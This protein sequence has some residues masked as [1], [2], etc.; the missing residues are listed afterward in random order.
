[1]SLSAIWGEKSEVSF[2]RSSH[3][4]PWKYSRIF[5]RRKSQK[6]SQNL[7]PTFSP[8]IAD[9][10]IGNLVFG[11]DGWIHLEL[12]AGN[13]GEFGGHSRKK[14]R[15][16]PEVQYAVLFWTLDELVNRFGEVGV[17]LINDRKAADIEYA[18]EKLR[19]YALQKGYSHISV[20]T[21]PGDYTSTNFSSQLAQ[22]ERE[23]Y[24]SIHL[25]N[26]EGHLY[27]S[28]RQKE[29]FEKHRQS[30][31][32]MLQ[33]LAD[34][35]YEG[36]YLFIL[37]IPEFLPEEEKMEFMDQGIFY[38]TTQEWAAVDYYFP[39]GNVIEGGRVFFILRSD[40]YQQGTCLSLPLPFEPLHQE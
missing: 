10:L 12:G 36:L 13:Y 25:K 6:S 27:G 11:F 37:D 40:P 17:M 30:T 22:Y 14:G 26:P 16:N 7:L 8:D 39:N 28:R 5:P 31:R 33:R 4:S 15:F 35:C 19:E 32:A 2:E 29:A 38:E 23:Y 1:M 9:R 3:F 18:A 34:F 21:A 24:D 20:I